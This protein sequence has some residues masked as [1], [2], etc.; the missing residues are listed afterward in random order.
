MELSPELFGLLGDPASHATDPADRRRSPRATACAG[1][2]IYG[3]DH[4][5]LSTPMPVGIKNLSPGGLCLLQY[6]PIPPGR[7]IIAELPTATGGTLRIRCIIRWCRSVN[8]ELYAMGAAFIALEPA[9][10][11]SAAA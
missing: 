10:P 11:A 4:A 3:D 5:E 9:Q 8:D 1:A 2:T 7:Q 6:H